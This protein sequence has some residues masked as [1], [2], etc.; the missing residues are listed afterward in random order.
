MSLDARRRTRR[1]AR[2]STVRPAHARR[3]RRRSVGAT[4][5][6]RLGARSASPV[7]AL[8]EPSRRCDEES[9]RRGDVT[10]RTAA[11]TA[12]RT[13]VDGTTGARTTRSAALG[14]RDDSLAARRSLGARSASRTAAPTETKKAD[15]ANEPSRRGA[16]CALGAMA[17]LRGSWARRPTRERLMAVAWAG[18]V[19]SAHKTPAA[20][21][22]GALDGTW[23]GWRTTTTARFE[24][25]CAT[26]MMRRVSG[27][28]SKWRAYGVRL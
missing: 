18:A 26:T 17:L 4:T 13:C 19:Q 10:R 7:S 28:P 3:G 27:I 12:A 25:R 8:I 23:G 15:E 20:R 5:R 21:W 24:W 14:R 6:S 22:R 11:H 2:A 16:C 1:R 9:R